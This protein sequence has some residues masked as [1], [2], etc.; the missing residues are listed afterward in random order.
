MH[1]DKR[2]LAVFLVDNAMKLATN[3][4]SQ[5]VSKVMGPF[6]IVSAQPNTLTFDKHGV[7]NT[8]LIDGAKLESGNERPTIKSLSSRGKN[9][10]RK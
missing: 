3:S 9:L 5:I 4:Y 1:I 2:P 8:V 7:H 10:D 6:S